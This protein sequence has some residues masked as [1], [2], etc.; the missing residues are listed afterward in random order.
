MVRLFLPVKLGKGMDQESVENKSFLERLW[1]RMWD[2][3]SDKEK[4][5]LKSF[6]P[7]FLYGFA[8]MY[9]IIY[10]SILNTVNRYN[11]GTTVKHWFGGD[12]KEVVDA[13][14]KEKRDFEVSFTKLR[15]RVSGGR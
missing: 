15:K 2:H 6:I 7:L 12:K 5:R 1:Y 11:H 8:V 9:G 4:T 13:R 14:L 10:L 3:H